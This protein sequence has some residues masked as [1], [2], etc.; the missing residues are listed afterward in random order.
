MNEL[1]GIVKRFALFKNGVRITEYEFD[2]VKETHGTYI[3]WNRK[4]VVLYDSN[5]MTKKF[6][7]NDNIFCLFFKKHYFVVR[8]DNGKGMFDSKI[9]TNAAYSYEGKVLIKPYKYEHLKTFNEVIIAYSSPDYNKEY[10][11]KIN[12]EEFISPFIPFE[13]SYPRRKGVIVKKDGKYG[14]YSYKGELLIPIIYENINE[15]DKM[16]SKLKVDIID[17]EFSEHVFE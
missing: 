11:Y 7:I 15:V 5:T 10:M 6:E 16:A 14:F 9:L 3:L 4:K 8:I 1:N 17:D 12:G 2:E 13:G